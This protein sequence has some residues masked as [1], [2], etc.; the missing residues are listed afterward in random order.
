MLVSG[1]G[2]RKNLRQ[3]SPELLQ[4]FQ[5]ITTSGAILSYT[6]YTVIGPHKDLYLHA[7]GAPYPWLLITLPFVLYGVFRYIYLVS[8]MG[9]GGAP[10]ETL[11]KDKPM[12]LNGA[13]YAVTVVVL[14]LMSESSKPQLASVEETVAPVTDTP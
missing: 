8:M 14:L 11:L 5:A 4:E 10:D 9:E 13:M 7:S 1:S 12:L 6:L 3:Y 2:T